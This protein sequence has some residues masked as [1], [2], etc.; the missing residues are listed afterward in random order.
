MKEEIRREILSWKLVN[1]KPNKFRNMSFFVNGKEFCHFHS[2]NQ[3]DIKK[4]KDFDLN[5]ERFEQNPFSD[6]W[7][8]F[9]FKTKK[10]ADDMVKIIKRTYD[11]LSP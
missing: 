5:D 2:N 8:L 1:E 9:N 10:D 6:I 4:P 3:M 11:E 7:F